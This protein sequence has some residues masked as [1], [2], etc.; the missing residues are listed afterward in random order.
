MIAINKE[1][2]FQRVLKPAQF[3]IAIAAFVLIFVKAHMLLSDLDIWLHIKTGEYIIINKAIPYYDIFSFVLDGKRWI[4]HEWLFQIIT[5]LFYSKWQADGLIFLQSLSI[6]SAFFVLFMLGLRLV[7]SY[8][9]AAIFLILTA[10]ASIGRFNI[11]PDIFSLLFFAAYLFLLRFYINKKPIWILIPLQAIWVNFHGYFFLGP[12]LIAVFLISE[13]IRRKIKCLPWNWQKGFPLTDVSY[14]RLK[15]ILLL[16]ILANLLNPNGLSGLIYPATVLKG[17]LL[18]GSGPLFQHIVELKPTWQFIKYMDS[19]NIMLSILLATLVINRKNLEVGQLLLVLIFFLFSFTMRNIHF[20]AFISYFVTLSNLS[21]IEKNFKFAH[22]FKKNIISLFNAAMALLFIVWI[23]LQIKEIPTAAYYDF[24]ENKFQSNFSGM[25]KRQYPI[26]A[27]EFALK[28]KIGPNVLNNF[29]SGAYMIGKAYPELRV[30][31]DGRTELYGSDFFKEYLSLINAD[32]DVFNKVT[33]KYQISAVLFTIGNSKIIKHIY[34]DPKWKLVFIDHAGLVFLKDTPFNKALIEKHE[35]N[36]DNYSAPKTKPGYLYD[37]D[38]YPYPWPYISRARLF[39]FLEKEKAL[40]SECSEALRVSPVYAEPYL[41]MGK[42]YLRQ[43][44][45]DKAL[46][47][48]RTADALEK[49]NIAT[50]LNLAICFRKLNHDQAAINILERILKIDRKNSNAYY[51]LG[52]IYLS[53]DKEE[54]AIKVFKKAIRY[55]SSIARYH[56]LLAQAFYQKGVKAKDRPS[57]IA[58]KYELG[59]AEKLNVQKDQK[60]AGE[61]KSQLKDTKAYLSKNYPE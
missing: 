38:L 47:Y 40:I 29:N 59:L 57:I 37:N 43:G 49:Q 7:K 33:E 25:D 4:D 32:V 18:D 45:Y 21:S 48:L 20:F 19:F 52:K 60:L 13:L 8:L 22:I 42:S 44:L 35:L 2:L 56:L 31:I 12:L 39:D 11:R 5:Y 34:K 41:L 30:F 17:I 10:Y 61:I 46:D 14:N 9:T 16:T 58:A 3:I 15:A 54:D 27:L 51:Y 53:L 1:K 50:L 24:N 23:V 55:E 28:N 26:G 36:L 6:V